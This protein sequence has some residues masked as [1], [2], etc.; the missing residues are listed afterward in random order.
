MNTNSNAYTIIYATVLVALVAA[1]LAYVS[2]S[3]KPRQQR[4]IVLE[5]QKNILM[6][7]HLVKDLDKVKDKTA[8][9]Q[10]AY[11]KYITNSYVLNYKGEKVSGD[12]FNIDLKEQY[13]ILRQS[14]SDLS[15]LR[16]PVFI[17][18]LND[19]TT[20]E[21]LAVYGAGLWGPI[22][23]Y[24]S[25]EEDYSTIYGAVFSH[26]SETPGLGAEIATEW[27]GESFRGKE[28]FD[29]DVFTS[30][31]IVKGG[32]KNGN[33]HQVDAI[34]GGS[35]TSRSLQKTIRQW[36]V[37]YLPYLESNKEVSL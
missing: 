11:S 32:V 33:K 35:I 2:I 36:L 21:V 14:P 4:N 16:L 37:C 28:I 7:V 23:G 19:S 13:D 31:E 10:K 8:Y 17:C 34:S 3:L 18:S 30:I 22:W 20:V 24:I 26:K 27:F 25:L 9:I 6:S 1:V 5:T 12:A 29:D 15:K